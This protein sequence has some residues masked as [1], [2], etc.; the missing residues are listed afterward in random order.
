MKPY[1]VGDR[2]LDDQQMAAAMD[3]G[4]T[5]LVIA[6]AGTGKTTTLVGR[7]KHLRDEDVDPNGILVISL[8]NASVDDLRRKIS[9]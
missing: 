1:T 5:K 9:S 4:P 7:L 2:P 6:G 8:T 3:D